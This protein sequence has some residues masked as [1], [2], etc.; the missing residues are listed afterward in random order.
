MTPLV[1]IIIATIPA[2]ISFIASFLLFSLNKEKYKRETMAE[3]AAR[4][5][6]SHKGYTDRSFRAISVHLGGWD[7][8]PDDLRRILV[9]S[10]AIRIFRNNNGEKEE[11]WYL[12]SRE[13]ERL[14]QFS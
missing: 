11:Y 1:T 8:K 14:Q 9:R 10:G 3:S 6:L 7:E 13:K 12:L 4:K 2:L 5:L